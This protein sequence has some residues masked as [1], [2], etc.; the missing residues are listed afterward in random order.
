GRAPDG[1]TP[2]SAARGAPIRS[3]PGALR[4]GASLRPT[5]PARGTGRS[6]AGAAPARSCRSFR[7]L[8]LQA[9]EERA[10]D[11]MERH[12]DRRQTL[13]HP[14]RN[15]GE[16]QARAVAEIDHVLKVRRQLLHAAAQRQAALVED[17]LHVGAGAG[18]PFRYLRR[19]QAPPER[20]LASR[21]LKEVMR[22]PQ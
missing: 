9:L 6:E 8:A 13:L 5:G 3:E 10:P 16:G 21:L 15:F 4:A 14:V 20:A 11:P 7:G 19:H 18:D 12:V 2:S 17:L 22:D 1:A